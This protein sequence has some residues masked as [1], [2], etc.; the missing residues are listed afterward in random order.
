M[1]CQRPRM[2]ACNTDSDAK[3]PLYNPPHS[4]LPPLAGK[5]SVD[6][7]IDNLF[8]HTHVV[9]IICDPFQ[10]LCACKI[11]FLLSLDSCLKRQGKDSCDS[12]AGQKPFDPQLKGDV[13]SSQ[14]SE[15]HISMK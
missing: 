7:G 2:M 15:S 8:E 12:G 4:H 13:A 5:P 11:V 6:K 10:P 1:L 9:N 3:A 14:G